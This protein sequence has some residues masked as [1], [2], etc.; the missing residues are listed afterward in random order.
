LDA[1]LTGGASSVHKHKT[2]QYH[3]FPLQKLIVKKA[4]EFGEAEVWMN[5]RLMRSAQQAIACFLTAYT[6]GPPKQGSPLVLVWKFEG[7]QSLDDAMRDRSFP[8]NVEEV[9]LGRALRIDDPV[10][11][12]LATLKVCRK[13]L[14]TNQQHRLTH[15]SLWNAH[16]VYYR[17]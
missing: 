13:R 10:Q 4:V 9:L 16:V 3:A 2:C 7:K 6:E 14:G 15:V 17:F 1:H 8:Y 12:K 11:R 5:E